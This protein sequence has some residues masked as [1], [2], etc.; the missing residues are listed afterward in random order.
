M[1]ELQQNCM[2]LAQ[3]IASEINGDLFY[4][5]EEDV[6]RLLSQVTED[7]LHHIASEI[8]RAHV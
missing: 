7:N 8:G 6:E 1:T 5:P 2:D 4:V 3:Q